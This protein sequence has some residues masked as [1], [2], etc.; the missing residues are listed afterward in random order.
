M[1][2][3]EDRIGGGFTTLGWEAEVALFSVSLILFLIISFFHKLGFDSV[4][5]F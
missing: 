2:K 3:K 1:G 4:E 5:V